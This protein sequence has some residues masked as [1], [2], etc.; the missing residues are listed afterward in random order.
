[1]PSPPPPPNTLSRPAVRQLVLIGDT[2]GNPPT[3]LADSVDW[4]KLIEYRRF[5]GSASLET[6][7]LQID[8]TRM[9]A[10]LQDI[11]VPTDS[12]RI[13]EV[14]D[15]RKPNILIA[16]GKLGQ[17]G[18]NLTGK[19]ETATVSAAIPWYLLGGVL[20]RVPYRDGVSSTTDLVHDDWI[21]NPEHKGVLT[22]N[23]STITDA[24]GAYLFG[25]RGSLNTTAAILGQGQTASRWRIAELVHRL[26]W[27]LNPAETYLTNPS[28]ADLLAVLNRDDR[29]AMLIN[30]KIK[31]NTNL[32]TALDK[33]LKPLGYSWYLECTGSVGSVTTKLKIGE[34]GIGPSRPLLA[35]RIGDPIRNNQ[36]NINSAAV[37]YDIDAH[38]NVYLGVSALER[39]EITVELQPGWDQSE[40]TKTWSELHTEDDYKSD[41]DKRHVGRKWILNEAG[42]YDGLRPE[43]TAANQLS[44][45]PAQLTRQRAFQP[46]LT[47]ELENGET[48][49]DNGYY[50]TWFDLLGVEQQV[51]TGFSILKKELGVWLNDVPWLLWAEFQRKKDLGDDYYLKL[52]ATIELD[53]GLRH[54]APRRAQSPNGA[55]VPQ[56][57][58]LSHRFKP[59]SVQD[60]GTLKSR[61][62]DDRHITLTSVTPSILGTPATA[63]LVPASDPTDFLKRGQRVAVLNDPIFEGIYTATAVTATSIT[64]AEVITATG[65]ATGTLSLNTSAEDCTQRLEDYVVTAQTDADYARVS[66]SSTLFGVDHPHYQL[67]DMITGIE[68]RNWQFNGRA[69]NS[70][71]VPQLLGITYRFDP[72]QETVLKLE[73]QPHER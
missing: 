27:S 15:G 46:C 43:L 1:M 66:V 2:A 20:E 36:T 24:D 12:N 19:A 23:R 70:T 14:R 11:G 32:P 58:D 51:Q 63:I 31:R 21:V 48:I 25:H 50:L 34:L 3:S 4:L 30:H 62:Y 16:W 71:R 28:L 57:L 6:M 59:A 5:H 65:T 7:K 22:G 18:L 64:V 68:P 10:R 44:G 37:Q 29:D 38:A 67:F 13:I 42:D 60:T 72:K 9:P 55:D 61:F 40:D 69:G 52:T 17:V 73:Q 53:Q 33:L 56:I 41:G 8:L 47:R 54:E 49:G 26:C 45:L 39:R 35:Q